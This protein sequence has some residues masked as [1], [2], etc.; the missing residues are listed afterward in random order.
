[1]NLLVYIR[2]FSPRGLIIS[3][4]VNPGGSRVTNDDKDDAQ[5]NRS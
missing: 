5:K 1:M 3:I 2:F 4:T